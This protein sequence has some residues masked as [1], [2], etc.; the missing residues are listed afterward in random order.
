MRHARLFESGC[1]C[2]CFVTVRSEAFVTAGHP[3]GRVVV[4]GWSRHVL[5]VLMQR[6]L[7]TAMATLLLVTVMLVVLMLML[8]M[9]VMLVMLTA[10]AENGCAIVVGELQ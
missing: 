5:G 3:L 4:R 9:L 7:R 1:R 8:L 6:R 10:V 2:R